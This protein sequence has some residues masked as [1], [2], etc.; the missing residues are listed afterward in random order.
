MKIKTKLL[1][2]FS[3]IIFLLV[4]VSVTSYLLSYANRKRVRS[5]EELF[6]HVLLLMSVE[7]DT[8]Y[9]KGSF[10]DV[11]ATMRKNGYAV[12]EEHYKTAIA[13]LDKLIAL[14]AKDGEEEDNKILRSLKEKFIDFYNIGKKMADAYLASGFEAGSKRMMAFHSA[15][16]E[17]LKEVSDIINDHKARMKR[18]LV[19]IHSGFAM[20]DIVALSITLLAVII[21]LVLTFLI[22]S[23]I[24]KPIRRVTDTIKELKDKKGDLT[25]SVE[26]RS[27]DEIGELGRYFNEFIANFRDMVSRLKRVSALNSEVR[28][29]LLNATGETAS[30]SNEI[31]STIESLRTQ[32]E[33]LNGEIEDVLKSV[34]VFSSFTDK[35]DKE[36]D[37]MASATEESTSS[38]EEMIASVNNVS[39]IVN[40]KSK[41]ADELVLLAENRGKISETLYDNIQALLKLVDEV[42]SIAEMIKAIANQTNLLS[43]NAAIEAAHA[44]DAGKGFAV[45]AD[46]IRKLAET[47]NEN[48]NQITSIIERVVSG[49]TQ[50]SKEAGENS[51][52]FRSI[53]EGIRSISNAFSEINA[54]TS[55]LSIGGQQILEAMTQLREVSMSVKDGSVELK[56]GISKISGS[57]QRMTGISNG[58]LNGVNEI[59]I[60]AKDINNSMVEINELSRKMDENSQTMDR[61]L[62]E[63]KTE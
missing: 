33:K 6:S 29:R 37:S 62:R 56:D 14:S 26:V 47:S 23:S 4:V 45:V 35:L 3:T 31:V 5:N 11:G 54:N 60:G 24:T 1:L 42:S 53:N 58:I 40:N 46:E 8:L 10:M 50:V 61:E 27:R 44:G 28:T 38:I 55:E 51:E 41:S 34:E 57:I 18:N 52:A 17:I 49:I 20:M 30:A 7:K 32:M 2:S 19:N 9:I 25:R 15:S 22:S 39:E 36:I 21:S 13:V 12:A 59:D 16:S 63:M 43:M 48:A